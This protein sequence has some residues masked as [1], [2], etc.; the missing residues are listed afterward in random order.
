MINSTTTQTTT[1]SNYGPQKS[2]QER[3]VDIMQLL[4]D[5]SIKQEKEVVK[6]RSEIKTLTKK[7]KEANESF[8]KT[9]STSANRQEESFQT[10]L[11]E[12]IREQETTFD[13]KIDKTTNTQQKQL[14]NYL[15]VIVGLLTFISVNIN[16]FT[17]VETLAAAFW[18]SFLF[19]ITLI[20]V[21]SL[22]LVALYKAWT[23]IWIPIFFLVTT[24]VC[25]VASIQIEELNPVIRG[26]ENDSQ[27]DQK[28]CKNCQDCNRLDSNE[29]IC[30]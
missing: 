13:K 2:E 29:L 5:A 8:G 12:K 14:V 7:L 3:I 17:K 11:R 10:L 4:A 23:L 6:L 30:N 26:I 1:S 27:V 22:F 24:G 19:M 20:V 21:I 28:F 16:I 18:F 15:T 9:I 25:I